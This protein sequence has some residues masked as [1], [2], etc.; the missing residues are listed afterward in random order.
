MSRKIKFSFMWQHEITKEWMELYYTL[1]EIIAGDPYDDMSDSI[2]LRP[3]HHKHTR[4]FTGLKDKNGKEIYEGDIV[5]YPVTGIN[6]VLWDINTAGWVFNDRT[7]KED[8][9]T[10]IDYWKTEVIGNIYENPELI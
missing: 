5:D 4:E 6:E 1:D 3:Y 10:T 2:M 7:D 8:F 9:Y